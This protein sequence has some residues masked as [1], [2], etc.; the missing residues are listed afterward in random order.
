MFILG[1]SCSH[2]FIPICFSLC[3]VD[4][5]GRAQ[6]T[7]IQLLELNPEETDEYR[8]V[9]QRAVLRTQSKFSDLDRDEMDIELYD[10]DEDDN[11]DD[12]RVQDG[13]FRASG[14]S[15]TDK[16]QEG[17]RKQGRWRW[18]VGQIWS[19]LSADRQESSGK[20]RGSV[21]GRKDGAK[22]GGRGEG[23]EADGE[24]ADEFTAEP[25][26]QIPS[27]ERINNKVR[28]LRT[29][30][31]WEQEVRHEAIPDGSVAV[32]DGSNSNSSSSSSSGSSSN[33]TT[34]SSSSAD[35]ADSTVLS[36]VLVVT[37]PGGEIV[38][39]PYGSVAGDLLNL[40]WEDMGEGEDGVWKGE[41][42]DGSDDEGGRFKIL[43]N[44]QEVHPEA[45]LR[46]GDLIEW[47]ECGVGEREVTAVGVVKL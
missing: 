27:S 45:R 29:M 23:E 35:M 9:V 31:Q 39:M 18:G 6:A 21:W 2:H 28:L 17:S 38:R 30:L 20:E 13:N 40:R 5:F 22:G 12:N 19:Q 8:K 11:G 41:V 46:D 1:S 4:Q 37:W 33:F 7:F 32:M 36:E 47:Q 3:Q 16:E 44:G 43:V 42:S 15:G 26:R 14:D 24:D 25:Q 34:G 10:S